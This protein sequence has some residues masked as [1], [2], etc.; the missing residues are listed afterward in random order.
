MSSST[1]FFNN[2]IIKRNTDEM[3]KGPRIST[4]KF[5]YLEDED[6]INEWLYGAIDRSEGYIYDKLELDVVYARHVKRDTFNID[7]FWDA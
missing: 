6:L 7:V 3:I 2:Y 1:V 5:S 4:E